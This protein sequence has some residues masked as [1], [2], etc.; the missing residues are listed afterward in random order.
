[1]TLE[2]K[3]KKSLSNIRMAR[4]Y[5][6]F[7][8]A[9]ANFKENRYKTAINRSYYAALSAARAILIL[10]GANPET[11][12]GIV[13][14]LSLRFIKPGILPVDIIKKFKVLL[15]RRTD[16]DYGDF[17]TVNKADAEDSIIIT[18]KIIRTMDKARKKI[19]T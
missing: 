5:E 2:S 13:T 10:E 14:M 19:L 12:E 11:H 7:E 15:S 1:M 16:V 3:D 6:F 4:A 8:D 18:E 17:E 9:K